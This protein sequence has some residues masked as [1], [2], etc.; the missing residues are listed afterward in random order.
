MKTHDNR[1]YKTVLAQVFIGWCRNV[2]RR[3]NIYLSVDYPCCG[4]G[5]KLI[6]DYRVLSQ[7][8]NTDTVK[9]I[10][11]TKYFLIFILNSFYQ[12]NY[13]TRSRTACERK[14]Y[15]AEPPMVTSFSPHKNGQSSLFS[16]SRALTTISREQYPRQWS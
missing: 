2:V 12:F 5:R 3:K 1:A 10:V 11:R 16:K 14:M 7:T 15:S 9:S 4:I 6:S 8:E 13:F